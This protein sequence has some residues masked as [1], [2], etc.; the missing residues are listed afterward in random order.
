[1]P[2]PQGQAALVRSVDLVDMATA[3]WTRT[4]WQVWRCG[5]L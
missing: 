2:V 5:V 1:L 3:R 4:L